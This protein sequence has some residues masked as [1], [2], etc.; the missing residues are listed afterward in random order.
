MTERKCSLL[1]PTWIKNVNKDLKS[2][3]CHFTGSLYRNEATRSEKKDY[4]INDL[5]SLAKKWGYDA[6][7]GLHSRYEAGLTKDTDVYAFLIPFTDPL[8]RLLIRKVGF[9]SDF[10][11]KFSS[12]GSK[13][14]LKKASTFIKGF[15]E[16]SE[17]LVRLCWLAKQD[18]TKPHSWVFGAWVL[19]ARA[20]LLIYLQNLH[21]IEAISS[22]W[23]NCIEK[24]EKQEKE[25]PPSR[26]HSR[27]PE[28]SFKSRSRSRSRSK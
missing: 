23:Q 22:Y 14:D 11:E 13:N 16:N 27:S 8:M 1:D 5:I 24:W 18:L 26:S 20:M 28:P 9:D 12:P 7:P 6:N 3:S 21:E 17:N 15:V 2:K 4:K 10:K 19:G 25:R